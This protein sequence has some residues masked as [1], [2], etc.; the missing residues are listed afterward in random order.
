MNWQDVHSRRGVRQR[1]AAHEPPH[2]LSLLSK[3]DKDL[4][5]T[6]VRKDHASRSRDAL[7][8]EVG[9]A[10]IDRAEALSDWLLRE[11]W[12]TRKEKLQG[13][14]WHWEGLTWRDLDRLKALIGVGSRTQRDEARSQRFEQAQSWLQS[15]PQDID[16]ELHN[17]VAQTVDQ[18]AGENALRVDVVSTRLDLLVSLVEWCFEEMNGTRRDFALFAGEHTKSISASDWKWLERHFD[19]ESLGVSH[20]LPVIWLAGDIQL[21]W[22]DRVL[23]LAPLRCLAIPVEDIL[24]VSAIRQA[25]DH[26]WLIENRASF[27]RQS[28]QRPNR[29]LMAWLPGRPSQDW[30]KAIGQLL[31]LAQAP[32]KVSA[33]ADPAG[34]DIALTVG[35]LWESHGQLWEPYR[36]GIEEWQA[37]SQKWPLNDHDAAL[38]HRLLVDSRLPRQMVELGK[39]ML[40]EGRKAE[41]EGWL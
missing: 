38:L 6:W 1:T 22:E 4:L 5:A 40:T 2:V 37:V 34:I 8:R 16:R 25:P 23:D 9:I 26:W 36:M 3:E 41:Q 35:E 12:I 24:S 32:L 21:K 17:S 14:S 19:L 7:L 15:L 31:Q 20:F 39:A 30:L 29:S 10:N 33:D 27:E 11:G 13:G 18:L 28:G